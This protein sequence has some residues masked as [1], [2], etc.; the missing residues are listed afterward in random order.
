MKTLFISLYFL[1]SILA[2]C[3][4]S[5]RPLVAVTL[6]AQAWLVKQVAGDNVEL[7][8][9][10]EAGHVAESAQP[11]PRNLAR[12]QQADIYYTVG[13][14]S[15]FFETRYIKP[16]RD[17]VESANWIS[18]F[19]IAGQLSPVHKL[20]GIDPH[21]WTSPA[22]MSASATVFEQAIARLDPEHAV[23][24]KNNLRQLQEKISK[25][26]RQIRTIVEMQSVGKLLVYHPAWGHFCQDYGLQQLAVEDEGKSPGAGSLADLFARLEKDKI[27]FIIS[28]PGADQRVVATVV[29]QLQIDLIMI[30]PMDPDWMQMMLS[31]KNAL[32][33]ND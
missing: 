1:F 9:M 3:D 26:D 14:P 8:T 16:Y 32:E 28:S 23:L 25:I 18:M 21:L 10:I 15:F 4:A 6:P 22:I 33:K 19:D 2:M 24:Y 29:E 17:K 12:F 11:G 20:E 31:M 13:D 27:K 30:D 7:L 5:A